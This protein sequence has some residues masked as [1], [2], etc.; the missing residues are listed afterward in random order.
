ME[1]KFVLTTF[2]YLGATGHLEVFTRRHQNSNQNTIDPTE[3]LLSW[4]IRTAEIK[5]ISHTNFLLEW[6]PGFVMDYAWI[7]KLLCD[8][9]FTWRPRELSCWLQKWLV[10]GDLAIWTV[11]LC[12]NV[13]QMLM[14]FSSP[15]INSPIVPKLLVS[16]R[17]V[18]AHPDGLQHGVSIQ[19]SINLGK[20]F[21]CIS[22]RRKNVTWILARGFAYLLSVFSLILDIIYWTV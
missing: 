1:F 2:N 14:L 13:N 10:S 12:K 11:R 18:G 4:C 16:R 19:I 5:N 8:A 6:V 7:F 20:T 17:H 22:G 9:A 15:R 21:L 3:I